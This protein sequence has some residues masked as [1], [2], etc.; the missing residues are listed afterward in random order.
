MSKLIKE[1]INPFPV[2][3]PNFLEVIELYTHY[4]SKKGSD[5]TIAGKRLINPALLTSIAP[6]VLEH[7]RGSIENTPEKLDCFLLSWPKDTHGPR[8]VMFVT[9]E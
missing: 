4:D 8:F 2:C 6:H 9:K 5:Y 3:P 1:I 7:N